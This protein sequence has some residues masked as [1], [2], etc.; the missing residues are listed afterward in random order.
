MAAQPHS[1]DLARGAV[2]SLRGVQHLRLTVHTGRMWVTHSGCLED[3][4]VAA[5]EALLL[6][7]HHVV[8]QADDAPARFTLSPQLRAAATPSGWRTWRPW[9]PVAALLG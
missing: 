6:D 3:H 4:F 8:L 9:R 1:I 5:G 2:L 7:G